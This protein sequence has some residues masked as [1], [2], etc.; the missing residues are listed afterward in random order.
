MRGL[1]RITTRRC[2][3]SHKLRGADACCLC[4]EWCSSDGRG[5][6]FAT[7]KLGHPGLRRARTQG[8]F[9]ASHRLTDMVNVKQK[10]CAAE[11]CNNRPSFNHLGEST[12]I[13]CS[14]HK[15]EGMVRP[16]GLLAMQ[17]ALVALLSSAADAQV[18]AGGHCAPLAPANPVRPQ[19]RVCRLSAGAGLS[20]LR[21]CVAWRQDAKLCGVCA[22]GQCGLM[23]VHQ[24]GTPDNLQSP[25]WPHEGSLLLVPAQTGTDG[26]PG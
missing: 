15:M 4:V 17:L 6:R 22:P 1:Q 10:R 25:R 21:R 23:L 5:G 26:V 18:W 3:V 2:P 24:A 16:T 11:A 19:T 7:P 9:C 20:W 12:G 13:F 14:A 8:L